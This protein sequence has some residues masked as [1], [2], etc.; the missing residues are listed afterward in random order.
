MMNLLPSVA[1]HDCA[2]SLLN[3]LLD[4]TVLL[5]G[6]D[7]IAKCFPKNVQILAKNVYPDVSLSQ[8]KDVIISCKLAR[9]K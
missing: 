1:L 4:D 7:I 2:L 8:L 3:F 6:T 9:C 5:N